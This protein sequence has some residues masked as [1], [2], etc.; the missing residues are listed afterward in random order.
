M[1]SNTPVVM[2]SYFVLAGQIDVRLLEKPDMHTALCQ[3]HAGL[4]NVD[5]AMHERGSAVE[6]APHL[7]FVPYTSYSHENLPW[8]LRVCVSLPPGS[9]YLGNSKTWLLALVS[10]L[11]N[12]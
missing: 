6:V 11:K 8:L 3:Q 9:D 10:V 4:R 1:R 7:C 2:R 12:A 5:I